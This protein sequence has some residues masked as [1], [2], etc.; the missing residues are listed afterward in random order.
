MSK[1][2]VIALTGGGT[3]GHVMPHIALLP[4]FS[5]LGWEVY[6]IGGGGVEKELIEGY[7]V[8]F[9]E[10]QTGKLRRY[11]SLQNAVDV[12]RVFFGVLQSIFLLLKRRPS[13]VFSKGGFVSVPA[14]FAA[15]LLRIPVIS[16]ESDLTPGLAN[17]L[18]AP[19][20]KELLYSFPETEKSLKKY[21]ATLVGLP[22][23]GELRCGD[24]QVG[25]KICGFEDKGLLVVLFMGGSLGAASLNDLVYES[26]GELTK[27]FQVIHLT[28]KGK[29][30][31]YQHENYKQ[32]EFV[33]DKL[34]HLL[35]L[36]DIVV[37]RAGANSIFEL[38]ALK[39][40][41]IL[42]PLVKG[43][44][45]DQLDNAKC[46][47]KNGWAR[48][49][50]EEGASSEKLLSLLEEVRHSHSDILEAQAKAYE[51]G[52]SEGKILAVLKKAAGLLS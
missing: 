37:C 24:G 41:M 33:T 26:L 11:F 50:N 20:A 5:E 48:L 43:S 7:R 36:S 44:R 13:V 34:S 16:H 52:S 31:D 27:R 21:R 12:F 46:F 3:A 40:P 42:V 4:K 39:K 45:G 49:L 25:R 15:W 9:Y 38:L 35:A 18:I 22:I 30:F 6:Y 17:K 28:G 29:A 10:I 23:R 19:F 32:F 51:K 47:V 14:C 2:T 8:P 1:K